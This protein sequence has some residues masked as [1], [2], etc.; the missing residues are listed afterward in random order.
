MEEASSPEHYCLV[1]VVDIAAH[2]SVASAHGTVEDLLV[3][4]FV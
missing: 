3:G 2:V 1:V 4:G